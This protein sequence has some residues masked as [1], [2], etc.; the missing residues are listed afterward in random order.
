[1]AIDQGFVLVG[2]SVL[3]TLAGCSV[4]YADVLYQWLFPARYDAHPFHIHNDKTFLVSSLAL[5]SGCLLL[6]SLYKLLPE[7]HEYLDRVVQLHK[8]QFRLKTTLFGCYFLGIIFCTLLN[9]V[10]HMFTSESLVHC[11]HEGEEDHEAHS[12]SHSSG[13]GEEHTVHSHSHNDHHDGPDATD[14]DNP[15]DA[16]HTHSHN[17][18]EIVPVAKA[19][20]VE[21]PHAAATA[22]RQPMA[23]NLSL[24]D[25]SLKALKG[26]KMTGDCYGDLDCCASDIM[27]HYPSNVGKHCHDAHHGNT[28]HFCTM[29]SN[30]NILFMDEDRLYTNKD[31]FHNRFP[32]VDVKS[33]L[34]GQQQ[35]LLLQTADSSA[36][37]S[38]YGSTSSHT[39]LEL[40]GSHEHEHAHDSHVHENP[41]HHHI[42]TPLSRLLSIGIQTLVAVVFHKLP[43]G[44]IMYATSKASSQLGLMIF[45]SMFIHNFVEGFT[46]TLPLYVALGSRWKAILLGGVL[47]SLA[48]PLGALAGWLTFR[49]GFD[50]DDNFNLL[51]LGALLALTAGFLGYISLQ[52]FASSISFGGR[53]DSVMSWAFLGIFLI[54]VSDILV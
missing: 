15:T 42:K 1:M 16:P 27:G 6:T 44:F 31:Q 52:M 13:N 33:P 53:Q 40:G 49:G 18:A 22:N 17:H 39:D 11:A 9:L 51:V 23:R 29:P 32:S 37:D 38:G 28:L 43:E 45:V 7:A 24:L 34:L 36:G 21:T 25:I 54:C 2:L 19:L 26:E 35:H 41:H 3:T 10:V 4:I 46:M 30:D 48:Q 8:S 5:S 50:M 20:V 12:H 47:G 14:N